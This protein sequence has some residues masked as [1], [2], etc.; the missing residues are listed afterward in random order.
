MKR[1]DFKQVKELPLEFDKKTIG[2]HFRQVRNNDGWYIYEV[3]NKNGGKWYEVFKEQAS[4]DF[5][6][7]TNTGKFL[8]SKENG[9]IAYPGDECFGKWAWSVVSI[10]NAEEIIKKKS[11][12]LSDEE[13]NED[14]FE[15]DSDDEEEVTD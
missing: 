12:I 13:L 10:E 7:D 5:S 4:K 8:T 14:D 15:E 1:E 6:V 9:H 3:S 11:K 2:F